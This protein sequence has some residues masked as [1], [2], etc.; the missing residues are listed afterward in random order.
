VFKRLRITIM[1]AMI[2]F[3]VLLTIVLLLGSLV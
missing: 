1:L 2:I 3:F